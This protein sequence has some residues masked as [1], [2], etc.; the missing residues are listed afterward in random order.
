LRIISGQ[1]KG[2][3]IFKPGGSYIRPTSDMIKEALFNILPELSGK[4]FLDL[5]AGSGSVGLEA[6]SRG[7]MKVVFVEKDSS[8][9]EAIIR[10]I[11]QCQFEERYEYLVMS[12]E[13]ALR[14]LGRR[15]EYFD[16][17][18][19]DPPYERELVQKTL[20]EVDG[21]KILCDD[22]WVVAQR[23]I[24]EKAISHAGRLFLEQERKY[25]DT[26]LSFYKMK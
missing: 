9:V 2:R 3:R 10:N 14:I 17:V 12:T 21:S 11:Q 7:A 20:I 18:F 4:R 23:S 6:L 1:A 24:R 15:G 26:F 13:K 19:I 8:C 25:G 22:G 16:I 5:F